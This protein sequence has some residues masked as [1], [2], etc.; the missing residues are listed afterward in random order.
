MG[1]RVLLHVTI[2]AFI[3]SCWLWRTYP[4]YRVNEDGVSVLAVPVMLLCIVLLG[5]F[6]N[7]LNDH[8]ED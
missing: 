5:F 7:W 2:I 1:Y 8:W 4:H 6:I 3:N